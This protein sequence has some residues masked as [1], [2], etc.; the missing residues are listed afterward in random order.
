[1]LYYV[2]LC[3][4]DMDMDMGPGGGGGSNREIF[5]TVNKRY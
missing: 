5:E 3:G 4:G 1:M 2:M